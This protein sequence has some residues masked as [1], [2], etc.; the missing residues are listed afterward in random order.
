MDSK[1]FYLHYLSNQLHHLIDFKPSD[2]VYIMEDL[3]EDPSATPMF[4]ISKWVDCSDK[5]GLGYQLCD[6]SIGVLFN[7]TTKI[8]LMADQT[9]MH[10]IERDGTKHHY[11][12]D[13]CPIELYRKKRLL[14]YFKNYMNEYLIK[15]GAKPELCDGHDL[16]R[17]PHLHNWFRTTNSIVFQL[18]NGTVQ[19]LNFSID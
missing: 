17:I 7:D 2:R 19:V 10:Y 4:W 18:T 5:Y 12:L 3:T 8:V 11:E 6:N 9:N 14:E 16:V 1:E 15:T 13:T